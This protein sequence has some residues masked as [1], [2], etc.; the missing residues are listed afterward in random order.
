MGW[1]RRMG[2]LAQEVFLCEVVCTDPVQSPEQRDGWLTP[3]RFGVFLVALL[4][5]AFFDLI[6]GG[7]SLWFS[8]FS[9]MGLPVVHHHRAS[10]WAGEL[11]LWNPYSNCGAPFLAQWGTMVLYPFSLFYVLFPLPWSLNVFSI[12]HL[13]LGGMGMFYLVRAWTGRPLAAGI[14]GVAFVFNGI[15]MSCLV[16]PNYVVALAWTPWLARWLRAAWLQGGRPILYSILA[17]ACQLLAGAPELTLLTWFALGTLWLSDVLAGQTAWVR[18]GARVLS[19]VGVAALLC[20]AQL[21]PFGELLAQS[22]RM[23]AFRPKEWAIPSTGW[24]NLV[25]PVFRYGPPSDEIPQL[26]VGQGFL[27]SYYLGLGPLLLSVLALLRPQ[28]WHVVGLWILSVLCLLLA[29]GDHFV[30]HPAVGRW[31]PAIYTAQFPV[32]FTLV[33]AFSL[34]FLAGLGAAQLL[35]TFRLRLMVVLGV[36]LAG[37]LMVIAAWGAES[38]DGLQQYPWIWSNAWARLACF[39]VVVVGLARLSSPDSKPY[40]VVACVLVGMAVMFDGTS[41]NQT[42]IPRMNASAFSPGLWA[43]QN[44]NAS[45]RLGQA[46]AFL[47]PQAEQA[48]ASRTVQGVENRIISRHLALWS[49]FN[50]LEGIPKVNGSSALPMR[51][52]KEL[53]RQIYRFRNPELEGVLDFLGVTWFTPGGDPTHWEPRSGA[54]GWLQVGAHPSFDEKTNLLGRV[55]SRSFNSAR[56]VWLSSEHSQGFI[57]RNGSGRIVEQQVGSHRLEAT[58]EMDA[59]GVLTV[60]QSYSPDW[61]AWV[62]GVEVPLV[63]ANGAFQAVPVPRGLSRVEIRYV[64]SGFRLGLLISL[65]TAVGLTWAWLRWPTRR[66]GEVI[67]TAE[68]FED[69]AVSDLPKAA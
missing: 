4:A 26:Q 17:A 38:A 21:I 60:A 35:D 57:G 67:L 5:L 69:P 15:S 65:F 51:G 9:A 3:F 33:L 68:P 61:R 28:R 46:R 29:M 14:A 36:L 24:A 63:S 1:L 53:E 55:F 30:L 41:H 40:G 13:L 37:A 34:P 66:R 49:H 43:Q 11:P 52:Q 25:L 45:V 8:D 20:A 32:K 64:D 58:V 12:G 47:S 50:L 48:L 19:V 22:H 39:L 31:I 23:G 42:L 10:V 44:T 59:D 2:C 16:W 7:R 56:E 62:N 18:S 27:I 54:Q 6:S